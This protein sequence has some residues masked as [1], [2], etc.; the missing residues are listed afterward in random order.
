MA[1]T[2]KQPLGQTNVTLCPGARGVTKLLSETGVVTFEA[3]VAGSIPAPIEAPAS[4]VTALDVAFI[5]ADVTALDVAFI[6]ADVRALDMAFIE[7]DGMAA[8]PATVAP[9]T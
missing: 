9:L 2:V 5:E 1:V 6:E 4:D 7:A 3:R 8:D